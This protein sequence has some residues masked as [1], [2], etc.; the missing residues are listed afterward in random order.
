MA[1][2]KIVSKASIVKYVKEAFDR[3]D[4]EKVWDYLGKKFGFNIAR[5]KK[6]FEDSFLV[7]RRDRSI[8]DQFMEFG[9][10]KIEPILNDIL[11]RKKY[12]TWINL[13]AFLLKDKIIALQDRDRSFKKRYN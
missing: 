7:S 12:P 1:T 3:E 10:K 6:E 8:Q 13:L 2:Q 11:Y 4:I 9:K 5:W